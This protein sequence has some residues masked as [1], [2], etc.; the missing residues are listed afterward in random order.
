M[1]RKKKIT[2][3]FYQ[4]PNH[5]GEEDKGYGALLSIEEAASP[6]NQPRLTYRIRRPIKPPQLAIK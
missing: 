3:Q 6:V 2:E 4:C 5:G 1:E